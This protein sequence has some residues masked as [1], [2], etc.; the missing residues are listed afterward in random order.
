[1]IERREE[2]EAYREEERNRDRDRACLRRTQRGREEGREPG[3][4]E[5]ECR[6]AYSQWWCMAKGSSLYAIPRTPACLG[7]ARAM[8]HVMPRSCCF[9]FMLLERIQ[10]GVEIP[11]Q[12]REM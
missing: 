1:M 6:L 9:C 2:K 11:S 8:P 12:E 4:P 10:A 3:E 5:L 7:G